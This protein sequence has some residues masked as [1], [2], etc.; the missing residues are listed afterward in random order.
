MLRVLADRNAATRAGRAANAWHEAR[1]CLG[2]PPIAADGFADHLTPMLIVT[3]HTE[4][5]PEKADADH[6]G[7]R[8]PESEARDDPVS[9]AKSEMAR[10]LPSDKP[11]VDLFKRRNR[12]AGVY[13]M[14]D[15]GNPKKRGQPC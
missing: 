12:Q 11:A 2:L 13:L 9:Y 3:L 15:L 6:L 7:R 8:G 5:C 10:H 4:I 1:D 14:C